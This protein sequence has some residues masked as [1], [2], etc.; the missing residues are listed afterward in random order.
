MPE[1]LLTPEVLREKA[2]EL[3]HIQEEQ[4]HLIAQIQRLVDEM[5]LG[6]EGKAQEAFIKSFNDKKRTYKLFSID[7][8]RFA[9]FL[10][11]YAVSMEGIDEDFGFHR[12]DDVQH[13]PNGPNGGE[14]H[15][16][17]GRRR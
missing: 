15:G 11:V 7:M 5:W 14:H 12:P 4:E 16:G 3:R 6:W 9:N 8:L 1:I 10:G 2:S 13:G 17:S